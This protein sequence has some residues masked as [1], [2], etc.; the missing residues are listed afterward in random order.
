MHCHQHVCLPVT[1][2]VMVD[3]Q[4]WEEMAYYLLVLLLFTITT[5]ITATTITAV[6]T[7]TTTT[8]TTTITTTFTT[9]T[10]MTYYTCYSCEFFPDITA[11]AIAVA[12]TITFSTFV[13]CGV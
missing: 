4:K 6:I 11:S 5:I 8:T 10:M 7:T 2:A 13:S 3:E 9:A 1:A 12:A